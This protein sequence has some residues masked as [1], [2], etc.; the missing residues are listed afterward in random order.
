MNPCWE[1]LVCVVKPAVPLAAPGLPL[2]NTFAVVTIWFEYCS[3]INTCFYG[4]KS[5]S[6]LLSARAADFD[7]VAGSSY[8][9]DIITQLSLC[10]APSRGFCGLQKIVGPDIFVMNFGI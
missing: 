8:E 10:T 9:W 2:V 6:G 1:V 5:G 3:E 4:V 7:A